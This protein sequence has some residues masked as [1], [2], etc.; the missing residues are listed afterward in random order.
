[1][2]ISKKAEKSEFSPMRKYHIPSL[3]AI[4]RGIKIHHLNIGQPDIATPREYFE[5]VKSFN[6]KNDYYAPSQG[7]SELVD[8]IYDYYTKNLLQD[9]QKS[10][11][12]VT[13]GG[14]EALFFSAFSILDEDEEIL[15]PEPF[16]PNY[17]TIINAVGGKVRGIPT[18]RED[19]YKYAN[20]EL[21]KKYINKK[22]K[23]ILITNPNNPTGCVLDDNDLKLILEFA[24]ENNLYV[25]CDEVYREICFIDAKKSSSA[26]SFRDYD[27]HIIIIDSISKRFSA[28]GA[29]IGAIISRNKK[30]IESS[31]KYAQA[32]LSVSTINQL[33][34]AALYK[35]ITKVYTNNLRDEYKRRCDACIEELSKIKGASAA[36]P[37]GAFYIM[38]ALPV[39][40]SDKFQMFLLSSFDWEKETV[41]FAPGRCFYE[42]QGLG[43]NEI[44]I[45]CVLEEN[46]LRRAIQVL[47]KG[48]EAYN[49]ANK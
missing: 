40:D 17:S 19:G 13:T 15:I 3:N 21:L 41:M 11:I 37:N 25:I 24:R 16:Y 34:G 38:A 14:S 48:I 49:R 39:D 7:M 30:I 45:A 44:R 31:M 33:G 32:R 5:A 8:A 6:G 23:A 46:H 29:R 4:S 1:M 27:E 47:S 20:K 35:N 10:D 43:I 26:L 12:V 2:K 22:T 36:S 9:I 28:C 18:R 42:T